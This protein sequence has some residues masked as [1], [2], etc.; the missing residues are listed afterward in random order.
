M[1]KSPQM[2]VIVPAN[3]EA[4]HI[5]ACLEAV[6]AQT[7]VPKNAIDVIVAANG[8]TD[9]TVDRARRFAPDFA[10]KGWTLVVLEI[11]QGGKTNALNAAN[12][13]AGSQTQAYLDADIVIE[14]ALL[15]QIITA[16]DMQAARYATGRLRITR[17]RSWIS[18]H[19]GKLWVRLPFMRKGSAPGAGL[20]AVNAAGRARWDAFPDIIADDSYVRWLFTPQER[21]EVDAGYRWPLVEGFSALVRVRARQDAGS[22]QLR[23]LYP[24]LEANE[25]KPTVTWHDQPRLA[26]SA[27]VSYAVYIAVKIAV[28]LRGKNTSGWARGVR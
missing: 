18:R 16:L 7:G 27:P 15:G 25:D 26:L 20:F 13:V 2:S 12:D 23:A 10:A 4:G 19:Y 24:A 17:A 21:T 5:E 8:C 28:K 14:P 22:D 6:L 1:S 11:A 3:N 9:D